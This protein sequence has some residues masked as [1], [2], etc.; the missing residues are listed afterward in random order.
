MHAMTHSTDMVIVGGGPIGLTL[1]RALGMAGFKVILLERQSQESLRDASFDGREIAL[2]HRSADL[3]RELGVWQHLPEQAISA[4][5]D[6]KIFNGVSTYSLQFEHQD[7]GKDILG[8][9]VSNHY[10]RQ[11]AY[12]V[13]ATT[14]AVSLMCGVEIKNI[15]ATQNG[16]FI[17]LDNGDTL[18]TRLLVGSDGR[19]SATRRSMGIACDLHDFGKTMLVCQ[20]S[21]EVEHQHIA[22]EWFDYGQTLA[23]LPMNGHQSSIVLTLDPQE[24]EAH[25]QMSEAKFSDTMSNRFMYRLGAMQLQSTR[26]V[27]PLVTVYAKQMIAPRFVLLGDAAVGMHPVTAHGFN[28]GLRG[29]ANLLNHVQLARR[30]NGDIGSKEVL[31]R[32]QKEQRRHT[33][34]LFL[35]THLLVKLYA[36]ER[37]PAKFLR[38]GLLRLGNHAPHFKRAVARFLAD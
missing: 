20:M 4:L 19:F 15:Q 12:Q 16:L 23:L 3:M 21:H 10:I 36:D 30:R 7:S 34:P 2:T 22:W 17:T 29:V 13:T 14:S 25:L 11:A 5:R 6:A 18:D 37:R 32:Y 26:H 33:L 28:F 1:A 31:L 38:D 9:L 24:I 27:Y 8:Y 35:A